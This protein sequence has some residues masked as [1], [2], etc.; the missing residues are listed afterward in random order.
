MKLLRT[1]LLIS[2]ATPAVNGPNGRQTFHSSL[3]VTGAKRKSPT[4]R[5]VQPVRSATLR[6]SDSA[7]TLQPPL[8]LRRS[9]QLDQK[10]AATIPNSSRLL[11]C[12]TRA[13]ALPCFNR[14]HGGVHALNRSKTRRAQIT[15]KMA[16]PPIT[17]A[18]ATTTTHKVCWRAWAN[19]PSRNFNVEHPNW[20]VCYGYARVHKRNIPITDHKRP[21]AKFAL[22][23]HRIMNRCRNTR[24]NCTPPSKLN[25]C[26]HRNITQK[27][28][29]CSLGSP[30]GKATFW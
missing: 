8:A 6:S 30:K 16:A 14:M 12:P 2:C 29:G 25:I 15:A 11:T 21:I 3:T 13:S 4:A 17:N 20:V 22:P 24:T 27:Q 28:S 5:L 1:G 26:R 7:P 23:Q 10:C 19:G 18:T 9:E